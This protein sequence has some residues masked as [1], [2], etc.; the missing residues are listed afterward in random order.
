MQFKTT[1]T[2]LLNQSL[3]FLYSLF[4]NGLHNGNEFKIGSLQGERGE[5]LSVNTVDGVWKDFATGEGGSDLISLYAA[6]KNISQG[7]A[8]K[9]I[10]NNYGIDNGSGNKG[11]CYA[12]KF[13]PPA[14][15]SLSSRKQKN[16]NKK[17][18][19]EYIYND[20]NNNP[21][22]KVLRYKTD[23]GKKTFIQLHW[24]NNKWI[25]G[26]LKN[27][28]PLFNLPSVINA[29]NVLITEGEKA[30]LAAEKLTSSYV[31][32]TWAGGAQAITKTD[33]SPLYGKNILLWPDNDEAGFDAMKK[34]AAHIKQESPETSIKILRVD[35]LNLP[36]KW[37]AAD[38]GPNFKWMEFAK[39]IAELYSPEPIP[40]TVPAP[41]PSPA[42][43][44]IHSGTSY[45][46]HLGILE[47]NREMPK[48]TEENIYT[49]LEDHPATRENIWYD[50]FYNKIFIK[51]EK[52][53]I[54][55]IMDTDY[56][57]F[58]INLQRDIGFKTAKKSHVIDA[59]N[60]FAMNSRR[61]HPQE[62]IT[63]LKWDGTPRV[64]LFFSEYCGA[65]ESAY[66]GAVSQNFWVGMAARI[67]KP[68]CKLDNMVI[69]EGKQGIGKSTMLEAI[70]GE[71]FTTLG[72]DISNKDSLQKCHGG[73]LIVE[74]AE[75]DS[76][77]KSEVNTIKK[78]LSEPVDTF[79][80]PYGR[81]EQS[82]KRQFIFV[83]TTNDDAYLRDPTGNRRFWPIECHKIDT[84]S[85]LDDRDQLFAEALYLFNQ[86]I[87]WY[88]ITGSAADEMSEIHESKAEYDVWE[89]IVADHLVGTPETTIPDVLINGLNFDTDRINRSHQIRVAN[90]LQRL[91]WKKG[92]RKRI[93]GQL[94]YPWYK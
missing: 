71:W 67:M 58:T 4:P 93:A 83:G 55:P 1:N 73:R 23:D 40:V 5:S 28:R 30:C 54:R 7:E 20:K 22:L 63:S 6:A 25:A 47:P 35:R 46:N 18:E 64:P 79:R 16:T 57:Q 13:N 81:V 29:N 41:A 52:Q 91:G 50:T 42:L 9:E 33:F 11:S 60:L 44:N 89:E 84:D 14:S 49:V 45:F 82:F 61:S 87:K 78:V 24:E 86:G 77:R 17:L 15:A 21:L 76:F 38:V 12:S 43:N 92:N 68:G 26:S 37:D 62:W 8:L 70:A 75:L 72:E 80:P 53:I 27:N 90:I 56:I 59:V 32:T 10:N 51:D 66:T 88:E 74:I 85:I 65:R 19:C 36:S 39:P 31:S 48:C 69:L 2:I 34:I 3:S 94:T